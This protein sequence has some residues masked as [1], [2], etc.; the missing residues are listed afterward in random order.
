MYL[1]MFLYLLIGGG[2]PSLVVLVAENDRRVET[3]I[4]FY[5]FFFFF[6]RW[7][8]SDQT[9]KEDC[10]SESHDSKNP[11]SQEKVRHPCVW[12]GNIW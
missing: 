2:A 9:E 4:L 10:S 5:P 6:L 3:L 12:P 11:K 1:K 8:R 7:K